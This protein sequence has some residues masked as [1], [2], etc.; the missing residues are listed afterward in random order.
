MR[1]VQTQF[2][3]SSRVIT[4]TSLPDLQHISSSLHQF[5]LLQK[6]NCSHCL[7]NLA[8][9]LQW[10]WRLCYQRCWKSEFC[11][12][13]WFGW[14]ARQGCEFWWKLKTG[15]TKWWSRLYQLGC[16]FLL[17]GKAVEFGWFLAMAISPWKILEM[18]R[19]T[20]QWTQSIPS[21]AL[22]LALALEMLN[23]PKKC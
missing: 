4:T 13:R 2:Q 16:R 21:P 10:H 7:W 12:R 9:T 14:F 8:L 22:A 18:D 5:R 17:M 20:E 11:Y 23:G 3:L 1:L 19:E 15:V 6:K